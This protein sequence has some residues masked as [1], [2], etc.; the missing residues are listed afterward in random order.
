MEELVDAYQGYLANIPEFEAQL[1][2]N[3]SLPEK[4]TDL[5]VELKDLEQLKPSIDIIDEE[6]RE[7]GVALKLSLESSTSSAG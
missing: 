5:Q 1:E 4:L 7:L 3:S 6:V 2:S